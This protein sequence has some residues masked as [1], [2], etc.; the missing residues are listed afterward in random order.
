MTPAFSTGYV[1]GQALAWHYLISSLLPKQ[2][3][4]KNLLISDRTTTNETIKL[5][6]NCCDSKESFSQFALYE[7]CPSRNCKRLSF[8]FDLSLKLQFPP[9]FP[10]ERLMNGNELPVAIQTD[11]PN[12]DFSMFQLR[13]CSPDTTS[14]T[15]VAHWSFISRCRQLT[16]SLSLFLIFPRQYHLSPAV[17]TTLKRTLKMNSP[18]ACH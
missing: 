4:Y 16:I 1:Q 8:A 15:K 13:Y 5:L 9:T 7:L 14:R 12:P 11:W 10:A 3:L 17:S 2:P 18:S 6:L